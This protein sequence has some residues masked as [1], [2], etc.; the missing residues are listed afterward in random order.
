MD[1]AGRR[2]ATDAA[3]PRPDRRDGPVTAGRPPL[4]P[5]IDVVFQLL[6]FFILGCR[7]IQD[8]GQLRANLPSIAGPSI[9]PPLR[10]DP[11]RVSLRAAPPDDQGVL[12]EIEGTTF[13]F[14]D[15]PKLWD[16]LTGFRR[17][18]GEESAEVPVII[19]PVGKVRWKFVVNAFNQ[20]I[21]AKF[22]NIGFAPP[23]T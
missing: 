13:S 20:A 6:L 5:M 16:Y 9:T 3:P 17:Q 21:R 4:T 15:V 23:E 2:T 18:Y 1:H 11:V 12:V 19:T 14:S 8:E 7:F 22:K 10:I